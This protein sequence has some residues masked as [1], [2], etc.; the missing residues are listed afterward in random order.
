ML[1]L[2]LQLALTSQPQLLL[3]QVILQTVGQ[4]KRGLSAEETETMNMWN[5]NVKAQSHA[6]TYISHL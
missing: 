6:A 1:N 2:A 4:F 3:W 5:S